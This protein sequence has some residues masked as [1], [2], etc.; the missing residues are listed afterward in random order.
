[1]CKLNLILAGCNASCGNFGMAAFC[2]V[3]AVSWF[4]GNRI[5]AMGD[6]D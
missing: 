1:M 6:D 4:V 5:G 3:A 2:L